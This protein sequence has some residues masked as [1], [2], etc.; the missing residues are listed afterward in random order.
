MF[1]SLPIFRY[2]T[3]KMPLDVRIIQMFFF[4]IDLIK[5]NF[6]LDSICS[7]LFNIQGIVPTLAVFL[8]GER[9]VQRVLFIVVRFKPVYIVR[10]T[11]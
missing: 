4:A 6:E 5:A 3:K 10:V 8:L 1:L 11:D 7:Y 9:K 2:S